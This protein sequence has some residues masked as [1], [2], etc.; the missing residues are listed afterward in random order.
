MF[1]SALMYSFLFHLKRKQREALALT[2]RSYQISI[3]FSCFG[4]MASLVQM[5]PQLVDLYSDSNDLSPD[6]LVD[7]IHQ[8]I[9]SHSCIFGCGAVHEWRATPNALAK[10]GLLVCPLCTSHA[11]RRC[12]CVSTSFWTCTVLE[13]SLAH[14][15]P[16]IAAEF[17][18]S[19]GFSPSLL[20]PNC[21]VPFDWEHQCI[22]GCGRT[23][24]WRAPPN[25][26]CG[27]GSGC[28]LCAPNSSEVCECRTSN[29]RIC[30]A[31]DSIAVRFP[32]IAADFAA[33][34][35]GRLTAFQVCPFTPVEMWWRHTCR[36]GCGRT[37]EWL[38]S[39]S[40]RTR[41]KG[42]CPKCADLSDQHC[43][44]RPNSFKV[45]DT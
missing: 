32:E 41:A 30:K 8:C 26:R 35:N 2:L 23:H 4:D 24:T 40:T 12:A 39:V 15:F 3:H 44:C 33:D 7:M 10:S 11:P 34:L 42:E 22:L 37:H 1:S 18:A 45:G 25:N 43:E 13:K 19:N 27:K 9:W 36:F 6:Q 21:M 5:H 38:S 16:V 17:S 14:R 28:P 20:F 29:S 31:E